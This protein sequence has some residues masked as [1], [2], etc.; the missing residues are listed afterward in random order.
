MLQL[1]PTVRLTGILRV[2]QCTTQMYVG[3]KDAV[4]DDT[5]TG[6][7]AVVLVG[8]LVSARGVTKALITASASKDALGEPC[9]SVQCR[10]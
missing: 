4:F 9:L 10:C 1:A 3:S 6:S 8:G 7:Y 2:G 5:Q